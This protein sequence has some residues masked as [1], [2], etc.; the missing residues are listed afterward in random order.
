MISSHLFILLLIIRSSKKTFYHTHYILHWVTSENVGKEGLTPWWARKARC[1]C[2]HV[3]IIIIITVCIDFVKEFGM[4]SK[5]CIA[6]FPGN[7]IYRTIYIIYIYKCQRK[8]CAS[9]KTKIV[10]LNIVLLPDC[11]LTRLPT[12]SSK[13][14]HTSIIPKLA[15]PFIMNATKG[16]KWG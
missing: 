9:V 11:W 2:H 6:L 8:F 13:S 10:T 5:K 12:H 16:Y 1:L 15:T 7:I 14:T 3:I 4:V